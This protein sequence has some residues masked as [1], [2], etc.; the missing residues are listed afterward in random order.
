MKNTHLATPSVF[1]ADL[2]EK[3][4]LP[5]ISNN[6]DVCVFITKN[7]LEDLG[8]TPIIKPSDE[9]NLKIA[10]MMAAETIWNVTRD[11]RATSLD[12]YTQSIDDMIKVAGVLH[13]EITEDEPALNHGSGMFKTAK[14]AQTVLFAAIAITSQNNKV[15]D[16]MN[17]ALL[18]FRHFLEHGAFNTKIVHGTKG[19]AISFNLSRFNDLYER[20]GG[21]LNKVRRMLTM[22]LKMSDLKVVAA[23]NGISIS[24]S[25]LADEYVYGSI[26]FGPKVGNGFFQ[27]LIGNYKPITIDLWFMRTWGRYTGTLLRGSLVEGSLD[28]LEKGLEKS[29]KS[30]KMRDLMRESDVLIDPKQLKKMNDQDLLSY[31]R[32]LFSFWEG[33]RRS[34]VSGKVKRDMSEKTRLVKRSNKD[35]S[36]LKK[37]LAW[38]L[39]SESISESL[40]K[41]V[42]SPKNASHRKWIRQVTSLALDIIKDRGYDMTIADMQAALWYPEK[43]IYS[44]LSGRSADMMN[45]SY[46]E[47]L[48]QIAKAEG[49]DDREISE[50]L[51]SDGK[52]R[53]ARR[54]V[55]KPIEFSEQGQHSRL[56]G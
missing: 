32:K 5:N 43:E 39:A 51:Q 48:I 25:E 22:R 55:L 34:Y 28:K 20:S 4:H 35:A 7:S 10:H 23:K 53:R 3:G 42:D 31:S 15:N 29:L 19:P 54:G 36:D 41:P 27:N 24:D 13:P 49:Y 40:G 6:T 12:W 17:Y 46:D 2:L 33:I 11:G 37:H 47:A 26:I 38:P 50:A 45:T 30:E 9:D 56:A 21:D 44:S 16:N 52:G 18:Q 14:E 8:G 1:V